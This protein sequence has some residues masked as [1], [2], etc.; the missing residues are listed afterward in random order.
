MAWVNGVDSLAGGLEVLNGQ[1][2]TFPDNG[3]PRYLQT[4]SLLNHGT[5]AMGH[6]NTLVL[7]GTTPAVTNAADGLW[8][9]SD[10]AFSSNGGS[11]HTFTNAGTLRKTAASGGGLTFAAIAVSNTGTIEILTGYFQV[12]G[13]ATLTTSGL[14][15]LA[16]STTFYL[17]AVTLAAGSTFSGAGLL[18][19]NGTTTVTADLT[20]T[21]PSSHH[22]TLTGPGTIHLA[23]PMAWVNGVVSLAGGLAVL[24][25][26]R[27][28]SPTTGSRAISRPR[29]CSTTGPWPWGTAIRS[30]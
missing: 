20:L 6:S 2:L 27:S 25:G 10:V 26:R 15:S 16:A 1:T 18:S 28:P 13:G 22:A 4:S 5:V 11:G 9:T 14:L 12:A 3:Q 17:D 30:S 19:M 24:T 21:V 23:A 7:M 8:T 29:R